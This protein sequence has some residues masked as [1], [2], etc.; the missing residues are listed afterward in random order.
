[1]G[2]GSGAGIGEGGRGFGDGPGIGAGG[3]GS[4]RCWVNIGEANETCKVSNPRMKYS[5]ANSMLGRPVIN[6]FQLPVSALEFQ[7]CKCADA[8]IHDGRYGRAVETAQNAFCPKL[9][10]LL[11][12]SR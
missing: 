1:M 2:L 4:G 12:A 7:H 6:S 10:T 9:G 5:I 3:I 8:C 11:V